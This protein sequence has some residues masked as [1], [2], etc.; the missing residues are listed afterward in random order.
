MADR[1][2]VLCRMVAHFTDRLQFLSKNLQNSTKIE[3][4][5]VCGIN[6]SNCTNIQNT[7]TYVLQVTPFPIPL[8]ITCDF[9]NY[10]FQ[11]NLFIE[12]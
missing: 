8:F 5:L 1:Y 12:N 2:I 9:S 4:L 11:C 3:I 10:T 7:A 6:Y